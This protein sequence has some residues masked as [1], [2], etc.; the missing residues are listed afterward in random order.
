MADKSE[1]KTL[2]VPEGGKRYY[3]LG[4]NA[5]YRAAQ[6]GDLVT[7]KVGK[8]LRVPIAAMERKM[9]SAGA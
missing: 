7:I 3:D 2:S 8:R 5:S 9:E 4:R 1:E 6:R